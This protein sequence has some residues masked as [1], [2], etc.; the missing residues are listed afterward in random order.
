MF[1]TFQ[2][3]PNETAE[4]IRHVPCCTS[5]LDPQDLQLTVRVQIT[6]IG[7]VTYVILRPWLVDS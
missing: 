2:Y 6:V 1:N 5:F 7:S 4:A 3:T